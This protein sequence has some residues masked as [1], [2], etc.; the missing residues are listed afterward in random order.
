MTERTQ[1][2]DSDFRRLTPS[3]GNSSIWR[4]QETAEN[5]RFSQKTE[6]FVENRGKPQIGFRHLRSVTFSSAL[7]NIIAESGTAEVRFMA[8]AFM[9]VMRSAATCRPAR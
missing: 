5:C 6:D 8:F 7:D 1:N 9:C 2:A 3:P 4:A